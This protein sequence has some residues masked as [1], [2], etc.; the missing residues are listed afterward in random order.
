[1]SNDKPKVKCSRCGKMKSNVR[2]CSYFSGK[3]RIICA[4]CC[5]LLKKEGKCKV[6]GCPYKNL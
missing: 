5:E 6:R 4:D 1:M 2:M 3:K